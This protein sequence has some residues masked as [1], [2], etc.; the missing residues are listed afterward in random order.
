M[1]RDTALNGHHPKKS[2]GEKCATL[3]LSAA[4]RPHLRP[5]FWPPHVT[6]TVYVP[7]TMG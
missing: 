3:T 4:L 2:K 6:V 7:G 5:M 1:L